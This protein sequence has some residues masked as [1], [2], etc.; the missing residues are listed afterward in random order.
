[1]P[2]IRLLDV[3]DLRLKEFDESRYVPSYL[4]LSHT[5]GSRSEEI[6]YEDLA[7]LRGHF[8]KKKAWVEKVWGFCDLAKRRGFDFV[9]I[10]TCCINKADKP[11]LDRAIRRMYRWYHKATACC[12][13]LKDVRWTDRLW[14]RPGTKTPVWFTRGWTLQE[15]LAPEQVLFFDQDW[16]PMGDRKTLAPAIKWF[17]GIRQDALDDSDPTQFGSFQILRWARYRVTQ[18]PEDRV[19]SLFGLLGVS[20]LDTK[21]GEGET[22]AFIRLHDELSRRTAGPGNHGRPEIPGIPATRFWSLGP[23]STVTQSSFAIERFVHHHE[24]LV[25]QGHRILGGRNSSPSMGFHPATEIPQ[26]SRVSRGSYHDYSRHHDD[27][28]PHP[29]LAPANVPVVT[30]R[31]QLEGFGDSDR[32]TAGSRQ[33]YDGGPGSNL[34]PYRVSNGGYGTGGLRPPVQTYLPVVLPP[35]RPSFPHSRIRQWYA[36]EPDPEARLWTQ[37]ESNRVVEAAI[38]R[39]GYEYD[40]TDDRRFYYIFAHLKV[41]D[42]DDLVDLSEAIRRLRRTRVLE[43]EMERQYSY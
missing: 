35:P 13:Y 7:T 43:I 23:T 39:M 11:E 1:M 6:S 9:W 41:E 8:N 5:W 10:D 29:G 4:I 40:V 15:L 12:V 38:Q 37:V 14:E 25:D 2:L 34:V 3:R 21:Y 19:Y 20:T 33:M 18:E 26:S 22:V 17:T 32:Q 16:R 31:I 42:M 27:Y 28:D 24:R 36:T 30:N